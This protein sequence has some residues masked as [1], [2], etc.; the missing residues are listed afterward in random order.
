MVE[1]H[2]EQRLHSS[3]QFVPGGESD[4]EDAEMEILF[5]SVPFVPTYVPTGLRFAHK[6]HTFLWE[7]G[8]TIW[9]R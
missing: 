6:P 2:A 1:L 4:Q 8:I 3:E 7:A 9:I 5:G